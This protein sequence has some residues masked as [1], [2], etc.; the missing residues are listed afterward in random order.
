[1]LDRWGIRPAWHS[2]AKSNNFVDFLLMMQIIHCT[3]SSGKGCKWYEK[4]DE[5]Q[6]YWKG[7][8]GGNPPNIV[9]LS[10][11]HYCAYDG[12]GRE[13]RGWCTMKILAFV[14]CLV[15]SVCL[16]H[17][18]SLAQSHSV[19]LLEWAVQPFILPCPFQS[20][21]QTISCAAVTYSSVTV[22]AQPRIQHCSIRK[23]SK[24]E[25]ID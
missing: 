14:V 19:C 21:S 11:C 23:I 10:P 16:A 17:S 7:G 1:M 22:F 13:G 2:F 25:I 6:H 12:W 15:Q 5:I 9:D 18:V 20:S 24:S 3:R 8:D 4:Q